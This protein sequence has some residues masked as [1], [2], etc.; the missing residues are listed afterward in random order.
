MTTRSGWQIV[1]PDGE[2]R[3]HPYGNFGDAECDARIVERRGCMAETVDGRAIPCSGGKH[4][5]RP[6]VFRVAAVS[7]GIS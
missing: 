2:V 6:H 1:C 5:I 7:V 4:E 3:L